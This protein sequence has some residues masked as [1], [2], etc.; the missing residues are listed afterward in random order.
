MIDDSRR[1]FLKLTTRALLAAS[2]LLSM[3]GLLRY[4][5][6]SS[7]PQPKTEF[8]L[9]P[10]ADY[11]LGSRTLLSDVPAL[12]IHGETGYT[13]LSLTCPHLGCTVEEKPDGLICPCHG[14]R[15][16]AD[17]AVLR[18]PARQALRSLRVEIIEDGQLHLF[19]N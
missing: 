4:L 9:G 8:D 18:G 15:F 19:V 3:R 16:D 6:Y 1:A 12:L 7:E 13:A 2:G 5:S 17:G 10:A 11:P 14:S